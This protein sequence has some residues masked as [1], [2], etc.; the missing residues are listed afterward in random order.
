[1]AY[2]K[3]TSPH[4]HR[5]TSTA[6][7]MRQV[8][9]A[10]LPGIAVLT[11]YFGWGTIINVIWASIVALASE[12][13]ILKIRKRPISFYLKDYSASLTAVLLGI[14]LPPYVPWW[15][16]LVGVSFAII[17]A[18]QLYGGLGLNPFNPAMV[19]Y[20][21]LLIS[22]PAQMTI[23]AAPAGVIDGQQDSLSFIDAL[24][25]TF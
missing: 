23:W 1:M 17:I 10:T 7:I 22:F 21:V 16:T 20:V 18:K 13:L 9:L 6:D 4:A 15:V 2:L 12:A 24:P 14:A 8:I 19:G 25:K 3:V 11:Y 5:P